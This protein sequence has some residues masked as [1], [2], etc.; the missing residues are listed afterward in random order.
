MIA[1]I[2]ESLRSRKP[3]QVHYRLAPRDGQEERW[4]EAMASVIEQDGEV[5]R[6]PASAAT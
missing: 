5:V 2:Q 6:L 4:I 1:A 3:Y